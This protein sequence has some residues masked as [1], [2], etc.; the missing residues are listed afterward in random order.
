MDSFLGHVEDF[1]P[2][3]VRCKE[4]TAEERH[5]LISI[6]KDYAGCCV[7]YRP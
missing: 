4:F 6:L 5:G 3:C 7:E 2:C 1:G